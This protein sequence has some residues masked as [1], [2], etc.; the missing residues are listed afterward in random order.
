MTSNSRTQSQKGVKRMT[1]K[2]KLNNKAQYWSGRAKETVGRVTGNRRTQ[3]EGKLDQVKANLKDT[4]ERA[5][6]TFKR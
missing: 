5:R 3:Y 6:G 4:G 2:N 1:A